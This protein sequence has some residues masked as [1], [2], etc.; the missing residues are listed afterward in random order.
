LPVEENVAARPFSPFLPLP[1]NLILTPELTTFACTA[2]SAQNITRQSNT[3]LTALSGIAPTMSANQASVS[4]T[5]ASIIMETSDT[6][7]SSSLVEI[8]VT[9]SS[10]T[11]LTVNTIQMIGGQKDS[12][13]D[14]WSPKRRRIVSPDKSVSGDQEEEGNVRQTIFFAYIFCIYN[15][16]LCKGCI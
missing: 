3:S 11:G 12:P 2:I 5:S 7:T 16:H 1:H 4:T 9:P 8:P 13:G 6:V 10:S 14:F 15:K